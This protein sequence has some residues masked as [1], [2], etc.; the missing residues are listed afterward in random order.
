MAVELNEMVRKQLLQN[1]NEGKFC[2][3][4]NFIAGKKKKKEKGRNAQRLF[5][6]N[7]ARK[8]WRSSPYF[9]SRSNQC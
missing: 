9:R 2:Y 5:V 7:I 3:V 6:I 8:Y 1:I 4:Q